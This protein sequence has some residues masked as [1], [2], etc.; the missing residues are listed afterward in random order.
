[1][2]ELPWKSGGLHCLLWVTELFKPFA[3]VPAI[4][5]DRACIPEFLYQA[6]AFQGALAPLVNFNNLACLEILACDSYNPPQGHV[7]QDEDWLWWHMNVPKAQ[8]SSIILTLVC[9]NCFDK[10]YPQSHIVSIA[11]LFNLHHRQN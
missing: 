7:F 6:T 2:G 11:V 9:T 5:L 10:N 1:M 8:F 3:V 4:V